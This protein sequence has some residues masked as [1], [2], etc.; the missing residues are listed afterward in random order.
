MV[1]PCQKSD[2]RSRQQVIHEPFLSNVNV[3][4]EN[5]WR[6]LN[7]DAHVIAPWVQPWDSLLGEKA[8]VETCHLHKQKARHRERGRPS[9]AGKK[10]AGDVGDDT[11]EGLQPDCPGLLCIAPKMTHEIIGLI[12]FIRRGAW[13]INLD[14]EVAKVILIRHRFDSWGCR[15]AQQLSLTCRRE[16]HSH[17][18]RDLWISYTYL[19]HSAS[20]GFPKIRRAKTQVSVPLLFLRNKQALRRTCRSPTLMMRRG[21]CAA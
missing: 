20:A 15:F 21:S 7:Q 4:A 11:N 13:S 18:L 14:T 19:V 8:L 5:S 17:Q 2:L 6:L 10:V 12:T 3:I 1:N 16:Q 9:T